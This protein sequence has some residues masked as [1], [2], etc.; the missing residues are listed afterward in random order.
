MTYDNYPIPNPA[1]IAQ[2]HPERQKMTLED[3][4]KERRK[5]GK[6]EGQKNKKQKGRKTERQTDRKKN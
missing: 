3:G 5:D 1:L 6:T 4:K 2:E